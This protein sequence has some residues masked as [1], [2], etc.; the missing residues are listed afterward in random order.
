MVGILTWSKCYTYMTKFKILTTLDL[1]NLKS[2]RKV[3]ALGFF[4]EIN[5]NVLRESVATNLCHH[6]TNLN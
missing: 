6:H 3:L 4:R 5:S 2:L 1:T